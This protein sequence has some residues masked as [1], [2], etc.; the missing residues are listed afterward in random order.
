MQVNEITQII[1]GKA[2]EVHKTLG[3][4]LLESAYRECLAYELA[5][6]GLRVEKEK[7]MPVIYK[8]VK[9]EHG[10]RLD[11]LVQNQVVIELKSVDALTDIHTAQILTYMKLGGYHT[12]LLIN[13]NV[14][15]LKNGIKRLIL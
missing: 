5:T 4:G 10:Y 11:L 3:L 7:P 14:T 13:F 12:G 2:I 8:E 15:L 1:I 9:L 6:S